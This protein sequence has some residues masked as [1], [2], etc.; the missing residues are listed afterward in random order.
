MKRCYERLIPICAGFYQPKLGLQLDMS[1]AISNRCD[2]VIAALRAVKPARHLRCANA[3]NHFDYDDQACLKLSEQVEAIVGAPVDNL[4][5]FL[6][7]HQ[8]VAELDRPVSL[9]YLLVSPNTSS[10]NT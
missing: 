10:R 1:L 4:A 7:N 5:A 6:H 8:C 3:S 9:S 2:A